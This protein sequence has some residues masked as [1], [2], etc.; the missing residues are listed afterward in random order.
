MLA[1]ALLKTWTE[2][3]FSYFIEI[4]GDNLNVLIKTSNLYKQRPQAYTL[5]TLEGDSDQ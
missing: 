1:S 5:G 3:F 2:Y 4:N